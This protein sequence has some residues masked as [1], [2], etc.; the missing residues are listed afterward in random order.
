MLTSLKKIHSKSSP[1]GHFR[2]FFGLSCV[3]FFYFLRIVWFVMKIC[4]YIL[5]NTLM[6]V[7]LK[8]FVGGIAL[9]FVL[10]LSCF[11]LKGEGTFSVFFSISWEIFGMFHENLRRYSCITLATT[12]NNMACC[13]YFAKLFWTLHSSHFCTLYSSPCL[14]K[15]Q[16]FPWC[17]VQIFCSL[18]KKIVWLQ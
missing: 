15:P 5:D 8:I 1:G 13:L 3:I 12:K 6:V 4:T 18:R 7:R 11:F 9:C 2:V 14:E 10:I 17:F 16:I